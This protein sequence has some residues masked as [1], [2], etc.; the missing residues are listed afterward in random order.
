MML[1]LL[2]SL[3]LVTSAPEDDSFYVRHDSWVETMLASRVR[4]RGRREAAAVE[5]GAWWATAPLPVKKFTKACFPEEGVVL[6]AVDDSG[7]PLWTK[8]AEWADGVVH[9]L[10]QI[11]HAS[12]YLF[13]TIEAASTVTLTASFGSDDGMELWLNGEKIFSKDTPRGPAPDQDLVELALVAGRNE[14]LFKIHNDLGGHGFYFALGRNLAVPLWNRI[15]ADFPV[16]TAWM[17]RDLS[18]GGSIAWF[19]EGE[20]LAISQ[21]AID[22]VAEDVVGDRDWTWEGP[23]CRPSEELLALLESTEEL[24]RLHHYVQVCE[25]RELVEELDRFD[26][27][28]L[29]RAVEDLT[30]SFPDSYPMGKSLLERLAELEPQR[31]EM[32]RA[33]IRG[34]TAREGWK[35]ERS[36]AELRGLRRKAL[37]ANPLLDF[38]RLLVIRRPASSPA[39]GLPQNWQG[40]CSLPRSGYR[41]E[42]VTIDWRTGAESMATLFAPETEQM[43]ADVDLHFDADRMLF[44]MLGSHDRWQIFELGA[45]GE[46]LRQVT[47][48]IHDDVDNYDACYLP[49]GRII[50]DSTRVFQGIPCV[51]GSDRVANLFR[52][53]ADGSDIRQLCFDQD[54]D[55]CPT[56]LNNGRVLYT[57]WEYSD[58]PHYFTRLLFHMN[59]DGT[60]QMEYYGSNSFWPNSIFFARPIPDHPTE[61]VT[62]VSG[63]H[64]VPRMGELILLD[65]AK[66]RFEADG[67]VQR[68]PGWGEKV[69]PVIV[70]QL[71]NQSWPRFLHP[72]PLSD[73]YFLA[74]GKPTPVDPWGIYLVDIFD[75]IV[76]LAELPG[77]A[78]VEPI[79]LRSRPTPPIIPDRTDPESSEATIYLADIYTGPGLAGVPRGAVKEL[80]LF[81][82]HYGYPKMG[83]HKHVG[84]ESAWDI[85]RILGTVP[86]ESDG[87]A[88]FTVPA[89]TPIALQ[90]LDEEGRAVQLMRSWF[91]AMPGEV[92][93]CAGCHESQNSAPPVRATIASRRAPRDITP[94]YGP[95]RG[96]SFPREVQPVLD[97]R[98]VSCHDGG[99]ETPLDLRR[100]EEKGWG[101]FTPS[102]LA[103]HPFV[104]RPGPESN[105]HLLMPLEFHANTSELV[106]ILEKGHHGV[107][108]D[109]EE[110]DRLVCWID[111]N[112]PDHGTWGEHRD[113]AENF[114]ERRAQMLAAHAGRTVDLEA[115]PA[116]VVS[117]VEAIEPTDRVHQGRP[118]SPAPPAPDDLTGDGWPFDAEEAVRL[119]KAAP[120]PPA[121]TLDL[122]EGVEL[123]LVLVPAGE[124]P[125][126][127]LAGGA[128]EFPRAL[129]AIEEPFYLGMLEVTRA[130]YSRFDP[131]H[132][133]GYL[134]QH[135]KDH[136]TP[137]YPANADGDPVIRV[138]WREAIAFCAW[139]TEQTGRACT[140]PTEAQWEWACRAGTDSPFSWGGLDDDFA[141]F[142]NL[143]DASIK[144][145]AVTGINPQPIAN[146]N[147]YEDF[148]PKE[149]RFDDGERLMTG[150]GRYA[151]NAWGLHDM[152]G[153]VWE[154]TR[155]RYAPYP[156][157]G[158]D[159]RNDLTGEGERVVRGGSW[160][161]RPR[162]AR[163]AYRLAYRPY[164][165]VH[166]VGFRVLVSPEAIEG[167]GR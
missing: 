100:K 117:P 99:D 23:P 1:T 33:L 104:R 103:L 123:E 146:P 144:R 79:P 116:S 94:W 135:H 49:D 18:S 10:P 85:H 43:I 162:F 131:T 16:E 71:V 150:V 119:Q 136:T 47:P 74:S 127:D 19:D 108:L 35:A 154:W 112:V 15:V 31:S 165:G 40:N 155:S 80:R 140:L 81:E 130:Q 48:G 70:D 32:R 82:F 139:L 52:M 8:R 45:D 114:R 121:R 76:L 152:H 86:I 60:G 41:D 72:W 148:L 113:I 7:S 36:V 106:Q 125:I 88:V 161:D 109:E 151:P 120:F 73:T 93:S 9:G 91:T 58:T 55:W 68:I 141:P 69:E 78:L 164:Q 26:F 137:G 133:N 27:P 22:R 107:E 21:Q 105:Y 20:D 147:Q 63:H 67:V 46:K 128:D 44:S 11:D 62:I 83:G 64:G 110:W 124:F 50:F 42:L 87:S 12:S 5:L 102:Y 118:E 126:G 149:I 158:D 89:N 138:S 14:L 77:Y 159:G 142:A 98:C 115:I 95:A 34:G 157:C 163:S 56:I 53:N 134:D 153:N 111:L 66:G 160:S 143:A 96:F 90:P 59:P 129:A 4:Y 39:L 25:V 38:D 122:G 75:N 28:A 37:L 92:L 156:W 101:N 57:R 132:D 97:R 166:N 145:L 51:T 61:V 65:P 84:V 29:H 30:A 54:H 3:S 13:R 167:G 24:E 6:D 17:K 2:L